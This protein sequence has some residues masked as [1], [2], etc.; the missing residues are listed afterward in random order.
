MAECLFYT[1]K[2]IKSM[3]LGLYYS[4]DKHLSKDNKNR[5]RKTE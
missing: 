1:D 3:D 5:T 2:Q 4:E